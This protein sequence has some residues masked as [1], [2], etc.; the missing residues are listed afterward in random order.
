MN[1]LYR[2]PFVSENNKKCAFSLKHRFLLVLNG[3]RSE[4]TRLMIYRM[5]MFDR[6]LIQFFRKHIP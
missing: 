4:T 3:N 1:A 5:E 6:V 2:K